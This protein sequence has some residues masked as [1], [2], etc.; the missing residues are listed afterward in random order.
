MILSAA[1]TRPFIDARHRKGN[2]RTWNASVK[3][4]DSD[5]KLTRIRRGN[6]WKVYVRLGCT[7]NRRTLCGIPRRARDYR[8]GLAHCSLTS[9]SEGQIQAATST[10]R[11][12]A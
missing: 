6:F 10:V 4:S 1:E 11:A 2:S 3:Q 12:F 5:L 7:P 9:T 8:T